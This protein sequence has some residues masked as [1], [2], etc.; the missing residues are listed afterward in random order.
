MS[1][2]EGERRELTAGQL[3]IWHA[4][5]LDRDSPAYNAGEYLEFRGDLDL[6]VFRAALRQTVAEVDA[7]RLRFTD[8]D[9]PRQYVDS[10]DD[11]PLHVVDVSAEADPRAAAEEWMWADMRRPVD[12]RR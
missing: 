3:A 2:S 11:W 12:L 10:S 7:F 4:Q 9:E 5:Q 1:G 6:A 8:G